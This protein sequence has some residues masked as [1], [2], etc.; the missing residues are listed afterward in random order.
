MHVYVYRM[1]S[2][3]WTMYQHAVYTASVLVSSD[4]H[5]YL[6]S[7]ALPIDMHEHA[8]TYIHTYV[9]KS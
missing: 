7:M 2:V 1:F 6:L 9:A 5:A 4:I 8:H 3:D